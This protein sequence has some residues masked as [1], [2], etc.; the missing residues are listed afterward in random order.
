[1]CNN[2]VKYA[3]QYHIKFVSLRLRSLFIFLSLSLSLPLALTDASNI[4]H[5]D[6]QDRFVE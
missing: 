4:N 3:F 2:S 5:K 6:Q 1:M